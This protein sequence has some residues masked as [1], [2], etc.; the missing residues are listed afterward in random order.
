MSSDLHWTKTRP[1]VPGFYF[2]RIVDV[3][4]EIIDVLD[5]G[6]AIWGDTSWG[7]E[8][9]WNVDDPALEEFAGPIPL[10]LEDVKE[11]L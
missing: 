5:N 10:P 2:A 8:R 9:R 3:G 11:S 1:T 4:I 6:E 7:E